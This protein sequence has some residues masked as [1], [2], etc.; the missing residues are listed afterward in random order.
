M[1]CYKS[2]FFI[3]SVLIAGFLFPSEALPAGFS[4]ENQ[5]QFIQHLYQDKLYASV[6]KEVEIYLEA[7]PNGPSLESVYFYRTKSRE[8]QNQN[9]RDVVLEYHQYLQTYPFGKWVEDAMFSEGYLRVELG[10]YKQGTA[11][12]EE[13]LS[14]F[15]GSKHR[16]KALYWL[17]KSMFYS[18]D[19]ERQNLSLE[20]SQELYKKTTSVLLEISKPEQLTE[21]QRTDRFYFL[22]WSY[23]FQ[24]R[25]RQAQKWL[26]RYAEEVKDK[27]LLARVYYQLGQNEN[28]VNNYKEALDY[29][30][31]LFQF[32]NSS[33]FKP[34]I[35]WKAE[36]SYR[37]FKET[38]PASNYRPS[39]EKIIDSFQVYLNSDHQ[40]YKTIVYSRIADLYYQL[41]KFEWNNK[42]YRDAISFFEN[43]TAFPDFPFFDLTI[44]F[45]A[46]GAYQLFLENPSIKNQKANIEQIIDL[47]Q[48]YLKTGHQQYNK[49]ANLHIA[50]LSYRMGQNEWESKNYQKALFYFEK[51]NQF[52]DTPY[53]HPALF[54]KA[55]MKYQIFQQAPPTENL[56]IQS[57]QVIDSY[58]AYLETSHQ[59][60]ADAAIYRLGQIEW[61]A[62]NYTQA[63]SYFEK[64]DQYP[65]SQY[66]KTSLFSMAEVH[67]TMLLE[68]PPAQNQ[69]GQTEKVIDLYESYLN[70][71]HQQHRKTARSHLSEVYYQLGQNEWKA[72]NYKKAIE[73]F[74]KLASFPEFSLSALTA[75]FKAEGT[76][77]IFVKNPP[78]KDKELNFKKIRDLFQAYLE[79]GHKEYRD[80]SYY[81]LGQNEWMAKNYKSA[82]GYF[83]ELD[84]YSSSEYFL[85]ALYSKAEMRYLTLLESSDFESQQIEIEKTIDL[86]QVYLKTGHPKFQSIAQEHM[87]DL[88]YQLGQAQWKAKNY[89]ESLSSFEKLIQSRSSQYHFPAIFWKAEVTYSMSSNLPPEEKNNDQFQRLIVL[90]E[91]YLKT[92]DPQFQ[93]ITHYRLGE[94]NAGIKQNEKAIASYQKYLKTGDSSNEGEVH[95]ELGKLFIE[96]NKD[97]QAINSLQL[98][99]KSTNFQND[100]NLIQLLIQLLEKNNRQDELQI[101]L[102]EAKNNQSFKGEERNYFLLQ[103]TNNALQSNN[104]NQ[105]LEDLT[106]I[107]SSL[108]KENQNY[109]LYA[110]GNCYVQNKE[111]LKA[112]AD[113]VPLLGDPDYQEP[114]FDLIMLSYQG[115]QKWEQLANHIESFWLKDDFVLK[116]AHFET[117][118]AAYQQLKNWAKVNS[119]YTRWQSVHQEDLEKPELLINWA[120]AEEKIGHFENSKILYDKALSSNASMEITLRESV[121]GRLAESHLKD[122][123]FPNYTKTLEQYLMPYLSD[124]Q[125]RQKYAFALSRVYYE[126][127]KEFE[128][129]R[130]WIKEVDQGK[131][132]DL[133]VEAVQLLSEIEEAEGKI[134]QAIR[135]LDELTQRPLKNTQWNLT[136]NYRLGSLLE[137]QKQ[138]S[139]ALEKYRIVASHTP[140]TKESEKIAQ[141][142]AKKRIQEIEKSIAKSKLDRLIEKKSWKQ[143]VQLI[144]NNLEKNYFLPSDELYEILIHA[145]FQQKNWESVL[146]TYEEWGKLDLS[147]TKSFVALLTQGQA[148]DSLSNREQVKK[149]Y[150]EAFKVL[151]NEDLTNR[152]FLTERLSE[153]YEQEKDYTK[154]IELY[155]KTYPF[156][157]TRKDLIRFSFKIGEYY[158][159]H[160]KDQKKARK[161]FAKTDKG[162]TSVEELTA[163]WNLVEMETRREVSIKML[164]RLASRPISK[165]NDWYIV[166][167]YK[168]GVLYETQASYSKAII[169]YNRVA[170]AKPSKQ[171]GEYQ[172]SAMNQAKALTEYQKKLNETKKD[173]KSNPQQ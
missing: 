108:Q 20:A 160:L 56:T 173:S 67:Y 63:I 5:F 165:E 138:W 1:N 47:Y 169:H 164:A 159:S 29:F 135:V 15:S 32:P 2:H 136:I 3:L 8:L 154:I 80:V 37:I 100:G 121:V 151:P 140:A 105:V 50:D 26:T 83:E 66:F 127:L 168:L 97:G 104:C 111:W 89:E 78:N 163:I 157:K 123:D 162:G 11:I 141:D 90:Y 98:A 94:L 137:S 139:K 170:K 69:V 153:I 117:L 115:S 16:D 33:L 21:E 86:Y 14:K 13:F 10:Q 133:E 24:Q 64:L 172:Q 12:L 152:I 79:T 25:R 35:F 103:A 158:L 4:E 99:R 114:A 52:P 58:K 124:S 27:S 129:A 167:N 113:L 43:L 73:N 18:A 107:P 7:F 9:R 101:L 144:R 120:E 130:R 19:S 34:A 149:F 51:L 132:S 40:Q 53:F 38:P 119:T 76:Y 106:Q 45:K 42:N 46:E 118:V 128:K 110:R 81:R 31:K 65:N 60:Y 125:I 96:E 59:E 72:G 112:E 155:E 61:K 22:G 39:L 49:T 161:W 122:G 131:T 71:G 145:E 77:Q 146:R 62:K 95:Y 23:Q 126:P 54:S 6:Q 102:A 48:S 147:K 166:I 88:I 17:G 143:V 156:L 30:E 85:P 36:C 150:G 87:E 44:F 148:S 75:F 28:E 74:D 109:L 92:S 134:S 55:E 70:S 82:L 91:S 93:A 57:R 84:Q 171:Y 68:N 142:N 41:G 116:S